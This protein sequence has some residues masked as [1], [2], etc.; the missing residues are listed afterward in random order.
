MPQTLVPI[1]GPGVGAGALA[2]PPACWRRKPWRA[3]SCG[4][5][6]PFLGAGCCGGGGV[7]TENGDKAHSPSL[8][9][10]L[11]HSF[12]LT[13]L[14]LPTLGDMPL[15]PTTFT[16]YFLRKMKPCWHDSKDPGGSQWEGNPKSHRDRCGACAYTPSSPQS[17]TSL[18]AVSFFMTVNIDSALFC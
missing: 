10:H 18:Q 1:W 5:W 8:P 6:S 7:P 14:S 15:F 16:S 17:P 4:S 12:A 3:G 11:S 13:C 9:T 2:V